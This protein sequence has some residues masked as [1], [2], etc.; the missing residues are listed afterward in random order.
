MDSWFAFPGFGFLIWNAWGWILGLGFLDLDSGWIPGF[1]IQ[2]SA[3]SFESL[4]CSLQVSF[5]IDHA[6]VS[7]AW[8]SV[9]GSQLSVFSVQLSALSS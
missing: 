6:S 3:Y 5:F 1:E 2:F 4:A 8:I 7:G 9:S